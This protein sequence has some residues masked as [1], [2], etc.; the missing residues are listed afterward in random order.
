MK[1]LVCVFL[2]LGLLIGLTGCGGD[3]AEIARLQAELDALRDG[4]G[5]ASEAGQEPVVVAITSENFAD[6][7]ILDVDLRN[8]EIETQ[9]G[10]LLGSQYRSVAEI[11]ARVRPRKEFNHERVDIYVQ[12]AVNWNLRGRVESPREQNLT[13]SLDRDGQ[14][15][16][17]VAV[18]SGRW[19]D[20]RMGQPS[21]VASEASVDAE[22]F[23]YNHLNVRVQGNIYV[24]E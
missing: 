17:M 8:T 11:H 6:F 15:D 19:C 18:N 12:F 5:D 16:T 4:D 7:F 21:I 1:K 2:V 14:A 10:G 9:S 13:L 3:D 22:A 20:I 24:Y 23:V